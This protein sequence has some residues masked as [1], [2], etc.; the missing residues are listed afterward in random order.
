[1]I[2]DSRSG[3]LN[4]NTITCHKSDINQRSCIEK[5]NDKNNKWVMLDHLFNKLIIYISF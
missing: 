2:L 4:H 5:K 3:N 1:M